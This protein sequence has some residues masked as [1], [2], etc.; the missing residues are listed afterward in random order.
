MQQN[1]YAG[2]LLLLLRLAGWAQAGPASLPSAPAAPPIVAEGSLAFVANRGQWPAQ[3]GSSLLTYTVNQDAT[4]YA[5]GPTGAG[6]GT[7]TGHLRT[8][9]GGPG[10]SAFSTVGYRA[11]RRYGADLEF[12]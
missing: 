6:P 5:V 3:P 8:Q 12:W 1:F 10:G 11:T 7:R 9:R 4:H 2:L